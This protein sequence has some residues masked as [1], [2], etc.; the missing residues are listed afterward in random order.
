MDNANFK[1]KYEQIISN[2]DAGIAVHKM[3]YDQ[4]GVPYDYRFIEINDTFAKITGLDKNIIGKTVLE[5]LPKT[6]KYWIDTY[7]EV[8][9]TGKSITYSNYSANMDRWYEVVAFCNAPGEF[10]TI[11]N[12]I[13]ERK[14]MEREITDSRNALNLVLE[15]TDTGFY[16]INPSTGKINYFSDKMITMLG[17]DKSFKM[18]NI[19][20][21]FKLTFNED[22][23]KTKKVL[24]DYIKRFNSDNTFQNESRI[25][26]K[27]GKYH[28]IM[29]RGKIVEWDKDNNP[30][31]MVGTHI[32]VTDKK[33]VLEELLHSKERFVETMDAL[34]YGVW[35]FNPVTGKVLFFSDTYYR[36]IGYEPGEFPATFESFINLIHPDD[37]DRLK[38]YVEDYVNG[39]IKHYQVEFR[40]RDK[41]TLY[42]WIQG[43]G[44]AVEWY[45][46]GR[47]SRMV[48]THIDICEKKHFEQN[49]YN[50][51][52]FLR[53]IIDSMPLALIVARENG[54]IIEVNSKVSEEYHIDISRFNLNIYDCIDILRENR[55]AISKLFREKNNNRLRTNFLQ[56]DKE[57]F[58]D[59]IFYPLSFTDNSA[60]IILEDVT[61]KVKIEE[62]MIQTEKMMSVGGLAAGMAHEINNPLSGILQSI[63]NIERRIT[64]CE[65]NNKAANRIG[66]DLEKVNE[67]FK[68]RK[69]DNMLKGIKESGEKAAEIV[70]DMLSFS[71]HP[72]VKK[73]DGRLIDIIEK[74]IK[75]ASNDYD[76]KKKYDFRKIKIL[77]DY[78]DENVEVFCNHNE[79]EQVLLNIFRN[80][81]QAIMKYNNQEPEIRIRVFSD[82]KYNYV[83]LRD[84]GPGMDEKVRK[85]IFEPFFTTKA[86]GEGT[87]LGLSVS[88]FI[89]TE[90]HN[91]IMKVESWLNKGTLI[92]I[93]FPK[94]N[95]DKS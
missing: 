56:D 3:L 54:T 69:I 86:P 80:A 82:G 32:D 33:T 87:G 40:L 52:N 7:S 77:R 85:R 8:V 93:G 2:I 71:R 94:E 64:P 13:S 15:A 10:T 46:D 39:K 34:S 58:Y 25:L 68:E 26:G 66:I 55:D 75:L 65:K 20:D 44:K 48:G 47:P 74:S 24:N 21:F 35:E 67:Y 4:Y 17:Y 9:R 63:Q 43:K 53:E 60:V 83:S 90:N 61:S 18:D 95:L 28:W 57:F 16:D 72:E 23:E 14:K 49:L 91:G 88:Y 78:K 19:S 41:N 59:I 11:I 51:K 37:V 45:E 70:H 6:E 12:D 27:D 89:I 36:M 30:V 22:I 29:S 79:I 50:T 76:L 1:E 92:T 62:M 42:H 84:N 5:V 73:T 31:R 81:A 38:K